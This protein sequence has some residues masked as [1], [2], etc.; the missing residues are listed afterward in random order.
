VWPIDAEAVLKRFNNHLQPH[1]KDA[2]IEEHSD[3]NSWPELRKIFNAAV[4]NKARI[5]S[6]RLLRSIYSLQ[7]NNELLH[8]RNNKLEHELSIIKK[9][10]TQQTTL[11]TQEGD[12]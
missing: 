8:S 10:L 12:N 5:K 6:K 4:A 3:S 9:R 7:V 11:T 2:E 1:N